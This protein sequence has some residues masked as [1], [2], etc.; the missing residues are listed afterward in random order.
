MK[1]ITKPIIK[2]PSLV[3]LAAG[4]FGCASVEETAPPEPVAEAAVTPEEGVRPELPA[5]PVY[6]RD[7][8]LWIQQRLQELGYYDGEVDGAVGAGTREAVKAYQ[9]D[10]GLQSDGKPTAELREFMWR[11]GG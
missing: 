4:V 1:F 8:V 7:D 11:N 10:Q 9:A 5:E 2:L 6:A 3:L